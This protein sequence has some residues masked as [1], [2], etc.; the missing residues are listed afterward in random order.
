MRI[1]IL[2]NRDLHSNRALNFL[3][4]VLASH[5]VHV[6][7]SERVGK[8]PQ[9][10][11]TPLPEL[12]HLRFLESDLLGTLFD[13]PVALQ[14]GRENRF[15][16]FA[17]FED[18]FGSPVRVLQDINEPGAIEEYQRTRPE[19]VVSI[20]YGARLKRSAIETAGAVLN[21]HSGLL[22]NYRGVL[23]TLYA[24]ANGDAYIGSTL[25]YIDTEGLDTGPIIGTAPVRVCADRSLLWHVLELYQS[26]C[27]MIARAI[28]AF[29]AG[30]PVPGTPQV[31]PRSP[32]RTTPTG[33]DFERLR[34]RGFRVWDRADL[35]PVFEQYQERPT[36]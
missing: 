23:N 2:A 7:L 10:G 16:S 31:G 32:L 11:Y 18:V 8:V 19:L 3:R 20:R 33:A 30:R 34:A 12:E 5:D 15:V 1:T 9:P 6:I 17:E 4:P 26:G 25:H 14:G 35:V 28:G 22:P 13:R 36:R 29:A 27:E 24:L 21:L